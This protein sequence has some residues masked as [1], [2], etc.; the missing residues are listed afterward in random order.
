VCALEPGFLFYFGAALNA[1]LDW[2][3][4]LGDL[5]RHDGH[6]LTLFRKCLA[7][8]TSLLKK[9]LQVQM[10][11]LQ[12]QLPNAGAEVPLG[13]AELRPQRAFADAKLSFIMR[14]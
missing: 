14:E 10:A 13:G 2:H 8:N 11:G 6:S 4:L 3:G 12:L 9:T 7:F 5:Q 1:M